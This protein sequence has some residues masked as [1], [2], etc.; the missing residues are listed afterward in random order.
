MKPVACWLVLAKGRKK[1]E[2][3]DLEVTFLS[4]FQQIC[5]AP[6]LGV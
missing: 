5:T 2:L 6:G 4:A 1:A 3:V